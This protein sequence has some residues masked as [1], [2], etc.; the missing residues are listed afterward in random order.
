MPTLIFTYR[1][2]PGVAP[3]AFERFLKEVDQP[4]T[5]SLPSAKA[6]RILRVLNEDAPFGYVEILEVTGFEDWKRDSQR[7]EVQVVLDQ[8]PNFGDVATVKAYNS[9]Q[10][11]AGEG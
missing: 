6:S 4:V 7:P 3:E 10:V 5:L 2:K 9:E 8:W 11:Y 1:P